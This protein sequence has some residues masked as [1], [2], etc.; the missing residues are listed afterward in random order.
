MWMCFINGKVC[1]TQIEKSAKWP[2][3][4]ISSY[5]CS[6]I[7]VY[8]NVSISDIS[9]CR[10][11]FHWFISLVYAK[12]KL[13]KM[14]CFF[15]SLSPSFPNAHNRSI[16]CLFLYHQW[17]DCISFSSI[18]KGQK[19]KLFNFSSFIHLKKH[20]LAVVVQFF[21]FESIEYESYTIQV[22]S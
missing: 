19:G 1:Y 7:K 2:M 17:F 4:G 21:Q 8:L 16:T 22:L 14:V 18:S 6:V 10:W 15:P 3:S 11:L 13:L 9:L 5:C 20:I 12:T